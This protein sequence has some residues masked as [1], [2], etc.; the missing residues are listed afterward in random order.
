[1]ASKASNKRHLFVDEI[2]R[3]IFAKVSEFEPAR[4]KSDASRNKNI[5]VGLTLEAVKKRVALEF[6]GTIRILDKSQVQK[7]ER[8]LASDYGLILPK[9]EMRSV[10]GDR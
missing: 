2:A 4:R 7:I 9:N 10:I 3:K 6:A 1:M 8:E 5:S